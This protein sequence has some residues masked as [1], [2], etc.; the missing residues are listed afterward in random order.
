VQTFRPAALPARSADQVCRVAPK[1]IKV[2]RDRADERRQ[3]GDA[4]MT[5]GTTPDRWIASAQPNRA[6]DDVGLGATV[7]K[8]L[9]IDAR[10]NLA[11]IPVLNLA[12]DEEAS[13]ACR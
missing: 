13:I 7:I 6:D 5:S 2:I 3:A 1:Q 11:E 4:G 9:L 12:G 8:P 10:G